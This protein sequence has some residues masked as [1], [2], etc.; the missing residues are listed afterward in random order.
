[1]LAMGLEQRQVKILESSI[2]PM[3]LLRKAQMHHH[4][5]KDKGVC[6]RSKESIKKRLGKSPDIF[7]SVLMGTATIEAQVVM[8]WGGIM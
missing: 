1:M 3:S 4:E 6:V 2:P 5:Y 7:D 8:E